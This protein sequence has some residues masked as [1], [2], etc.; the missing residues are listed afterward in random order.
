MSRLRPTPLPCAAVQ[1]FSV[2][3]FGWTQAVETACYR[4]KPTEGGLQKGWP[5]R[6]PFRFKWV[7][8]HL[9]GSCRVSTRSGLTTEKPF[10]AALFGSALEAFG[11]YC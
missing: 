10:A 5:A 8:T 4:R 2:V 9:P 3:W 1:G 6:F 11:V 7:L